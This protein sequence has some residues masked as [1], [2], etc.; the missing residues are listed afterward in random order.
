MSDRR[1]LEGFV[2]P[3]TAMVRPWSEWCYELL[4]GVGGLAPLRAA[5]CKTRLFSREGCVA[6]D[7]PVCHELVDPSCR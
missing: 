7:F 1:F 2:F 5:R 3:W 6:Y 4:V